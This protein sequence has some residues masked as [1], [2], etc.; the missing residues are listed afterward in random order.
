MSTFIDWLERANERNTRVRAVLRRSLAFD[1]GAHPAAYPYV[2][3][4]LSDDD[5]GWRRQVHYLVAALWAM[6]WKAGR[7]EP[8]LPM[9]EAMA[10]YAMQRHTREQLD[11]GDSST[12]RRFVA[13][14]DADAQQLPHRLRQVIALLKDEAI[15]FN[16][17]LTDLLRW[18]VSHKPAQQIWAREFYRA[19]RPITSTDN[20]TTIQEETA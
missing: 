3:P 4:F 2:E 18:H 17:L 6:H 9:G 7:S 1:P 5:S 11:K 16:A 8:V 19:L 13:L 14:L 12:E 20:P 15:D 10:R